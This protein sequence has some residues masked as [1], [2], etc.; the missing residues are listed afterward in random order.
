M[1]AYEKDEIMTRFKNNEFK[2]LVAT[3]VIEVGVD[4]PNANVMVIEHAER[5]GLAQLHQLRGRVGRGSEAAYCI[6]LYHLP[7]SDVGRKRLQLMKETTDGFLLSEADLTLRGA[8]DILGRDQSGFDV[9]RFSDFS[10]N[11]SLLEVADE[12][13]ERM[14]LNS[15]ETAA[16]CDIFKRVSDENIV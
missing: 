7:I 10:E 4:I 1:K 6:L 2:L 16:L 12:I 15:P 9:L 14:N 5:F 8:G 11:Y 13:S 3:T